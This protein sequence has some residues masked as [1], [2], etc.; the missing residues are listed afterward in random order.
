[1]CRDLEQVRRELRR[2]ED[3]ADKEPGPA[4]TES[5]VELLAAR[6]GSLSE[7]E[8]RIF[9]EKIV[10]SLNYDSRPVRHSSLPQAHRNTFQWAFDSRLSE[11]F[12]S[13]SG[14][15]WV[16]GK[17]GSGKS[18]F[19][20]FIASH[21]QTKE[22]L[23]RWSGSM[24]T[25]AVGAHFFWI[26]GTAIQKSWQGLLQ[27]LLFDVLYKHPSVIPL[28]SPARWA[29][30]KTGQIQTVT[31]PWSVTEL[32]AALRALASTKDMP[33]KICFFIDGL[34][35]YS[36]DHNELCNVLR[37][38]ASS[39]HIKMCLSSRPWAVFE[40]SFGGDDAKRLDI[41]ELTRNDIWGFVSDQ[42]QGHPRWAD[43]ATQ[44]VSLQKARLIEQIAA[45][46]AGVFLWAFF[47]TRL[48]QE[49][50]S[51]GVMISDM[52]ERL[53]ELPSD[54]EHLFKHILQSVSSIDH[55]KMAG[56]LQTT[57]YA[58][59]P[60]H[61]DLYWLVEKEVDEYDHAYQCQIGATPPE[62]ILQQREQISRSIDDKTK[63]LLKVVHQRVE[64]L[65]RTVKDFV[66]TR[67][68]GDYLRE[69]L[70]ADYNGFISIATAYM[71]FLKT[72][73]QDRTLVA[74]ITKQGLG[75]NSGPFVSHLNQALKY[76]SE[77]LKLDQQVSFPHITRLLDAYE[78]A[79]D[80]MVRIGHIT[81]RGFKSQ[82]CDPRLLF[83]E[84]ILR[85]DFTLYI[86][87]RLQDEPTFFDIFDEPPLYAALTPMS[88]SSSESPAPVP[89]IVDLILQRQGDPNITPPQ[90]G[91]LD[92]VSPWVLFA[93]GVMSVF[94]MLSGPLMFPAL[95]FNDSLKNGLFDLLL[96]HGANP[97]QPLLNR[98]G[99]HTVFS[100]FLDISLSSFLGP[101]CFDGYLRTMDAFLRAGASLGT[102]EVVIADSEGF[103][104]FGNLARPRPDES[105]LTSYCTELQ[106]LQPRLAADSER[107]AFISS[108]TKKLIYACSSNKDGLTQ[109]AVAVSA[110]CPEHIRGPLLQL[111]ESELGSQVL[112]KRRRDSSE[113]PSSPVSRRI[114]YQ[115]KLSSTYP[116]SSLP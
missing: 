63:G 96:A 41:H 44:E 6:L 106:T 98:S 39:P 21:A 84:E 12:S 1:M 52:H 81:M 59:E 100:H 16:S 101:E 102:P 104:A 45:S 30:A 112:Q 27:S 97:N 60:L 64:F 55:S 85:H 3:V 5:D 7:A 79:I 31:E 93:R 86:S 65:H 32:M 2:V 10:A 107:A 71:G 56:V 87:K 95:R 20:K 49:D 15:F 42:L 110:G 47:V 70:P 78:A 115:S 92:V 26:A 9:A 53:R 33:L 73:C 91:G 14:I 34:D 67:D 77:A 90:S 18:T 62:L 76:A 82:S 111:V 46:S 109:L 36:S 68:V 72:Q 23:A 43:E 38:M 114:R 19:M 51:A 25:L 58:L 13:G 113:E 80:R 54:L 28:I 11:W 35:E 37:D 108:V 61:I 103:G 74:G 116:S 69:K 22:L 57:A 88:I 83:R 48:L 4:F 105:L 94:N 8:D 75:S 40:D 66:L 17:P 89:G 50:L 29:A 24:E 99:A